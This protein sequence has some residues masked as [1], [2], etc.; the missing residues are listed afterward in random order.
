MLALSLSAG[1]KETGDIQVKSIEFTGVHAFPASDLEAVLA[2]RESGWLPW[3]AKHYFDRA[4]FESDLD[5]IHAYYAD[6][7]YPDERI[8]HVSADVNPE[9]TSVQIHIEV[10]EGEPVIVQA[11]R[12]EGFDVVPDSARGALDSAPL[13][14]DA[15]RDRNLV[16]ASR[17]L[18]AGL[19]RDQ[20][21]PYAYVDAGERPGDAPGQ[22]I[23]TFRADPGDQM[24]FGETTIDGLERVRESVV[25]R[26]VSFKPGQTFRESAI[27]RTQRRL[28]SQEIFQLV[29]VTP[30]LDEP[31]GG[32]IPVRVTLAEG[33]PRLLRFGVGYGTEE[34]AR[35]TLSWQHLNLFGTAQHLETEAS[36]SFIKQ[37]ANISYV[38]PYLGRP[39]L[40]LRVT[41]VAENVEQLTYDSQSYGGRFVVRYRPSGGRGTAAF[42]PVRYDV[43]AGYRHEYLRYGISPDSL[44]DLTQ[45]DE[46][47][48]LGLDP[49]TG[50]GKGTLAAVNFDLER[51]AVDD[52]LE[53]RKGTIGSFHFEHAA[54]WLGG[55]YKFNEVLLDGRGYLPVGSVVLA[56]HVEYGTV[57]AKD[58]ATVP[59]SKRYFLGGATSLRGWGRYQVAP[60]DEQ[61]L[62]IGGRTLVA[63]SLEARFPV[64]GK[65]SGVAFVDAGS[66]GSSDFNVERLRLRYDI[67]PGLRYQTPIGALRADLGYQL[68]P[69]EGLSINGEIPAKPRPWRVHVS[70]GQAF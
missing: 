20:G 40:S 4:E 9:H 53:P 17:D 18:A 43:R 37:S 42:E 44:Q 10:D 24:Q 31:N 38:D 2:T 51:A 23:V 25:R 13:K 56:A 48:A 46:R 64:H 50:R 59:F 6:H 28:T 69:I 29:A 60:L 34:R 49:E 66:V 32:R 35:G 22:V 68:T 52:A 16:R 11:V 47:I 30:Q 1:C 3:S 36:A 27:L 33:K 5:R 15:P 62:P 21:Y 14:A 65:L 55:T 26:L 12:F 54:P 57:A 19:L 8:A 58:P 7:G 45:R 61:G 39:R 67:G 70:I 63:G 41:A